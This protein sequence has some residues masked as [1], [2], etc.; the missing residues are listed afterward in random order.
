MYL[1]CNNAQEFVSFSMK[2]TE[3]RKTLDKSLNRF[4]NITIFILCAQLGRQGE[5]AFRN[6]A[7]SLGVDKIFTVYPTV[8]TLGLSLIRL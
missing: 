4:R 5:V 2:F 1:H 6:D 7:A 8:Q 3:V